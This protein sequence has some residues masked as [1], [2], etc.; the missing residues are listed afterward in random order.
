MVLPYCTACK[1]SE[2]GARVSLILCTESLPL[3][4]GCDVGLLT[5]LRPK[6]H[7]RSPPADE[8]GGGGQWGLSGF[9]FGRQTGVRTRAWPAKL[10][11]AR[12]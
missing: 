10:S 9:G 4:Q 7:P 11:M 2:D 1:T 8:K 5:H 3:T 12:P 6:A